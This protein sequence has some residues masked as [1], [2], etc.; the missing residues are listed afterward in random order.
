MHVSLPSRVSCMS[1]QW[2]YPLVL[3]QQSDMRPASR[4]Q[5]QALSGII[6]TAIAKVHRPPMGKP[7]LQERPRGGDGVVDDAV[8]ELAGPQI[9]RLDGP[10]Q[11]LKG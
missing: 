1:V 5:M 6:S 3:P 2:R 10:G 8:A 7:R 11:S 4:R 9:V